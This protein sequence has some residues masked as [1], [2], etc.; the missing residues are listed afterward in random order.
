MV[1]KWE[2]YVNLILHCLFWLER[3]GERLYL[4]CCVCIYFSLC[5][6]VVGYLSPSCSVSEL[7]PAL[8]Y[9]C[10]GILMYLY[11]SHSV[12]T[13][14]PWCIYILA[15]VYLHPEHNVSTSWPWCI[16]IPASQTRHQTV[17]LLSAFTSCQKQISFQE[18]RAIF[19]KT[20]MGD[21]INLWII[22]CTNVLFDVVN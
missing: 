12:S 16:Y 14:W 10:L 6:M 2:W 9:L 22:L 21:M 13:S 15:V 20:E 5:I 11:L 4:F 8:L 3:E 19:A 18:Q 7:Y 17:I 1:T